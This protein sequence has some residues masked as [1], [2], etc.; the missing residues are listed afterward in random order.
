MVTIN[1]NP[2][3]SIV[4]PVYNGSNYVREAIDSALAQTYKNIEI[5]VVNDGSKDNTEEI[6][7]SYGDKV[8]YFSKEN[9]GTTTAL[10]VGI[11]NM[12]GSYFSWLSHD[13][14]YYPTKIA[15]Q[16]DELSKLEN[17]DTIIMSDLDGINEKYKK[18]YQTDY[19]KH[20]DKYPPRLKS[21][22]HPVIYNQT[23]GCTLLI[24][25][26]CFDTVGLFDESQL[27]AQ[28]FEFF[29]RAFLKFPHKLISEVLVTARDSSKRQ[30]IRSKSRGNEEYSALFI[31]VINN[32]TDEDIKLL[33]SDKLTFYHDMRDFFQCAE[34]SIALEYIEKKIVKNLQISSYDLIGNKFN[35]YDLHLD[36]R[37]NAIDSKQLVLFKESDDFNTYAYDFNTKDATKGLIQERIF[38]ESDIVHLHLIH[39]IIDLNYLPIMTKLKPTIL[40]LHDPFFLGG[41]CVHHFD[42]KKW[43]V[44]CK[45]CS[46]INE[47]FVLDKD[48]SA[49][50]F[51]L[52]KQAIQNSQITAV[53]ASNWMKNKVEQSPIWQGKKAYLLPFGVNQK[54]FDAVDIKLAKAK[55]NIQEKSIT[56]MFRADAGSYKGL[57]IIKHALA[58]LKN[59]KTITLITV[60]QKGLLKGF[61][62]KF[63]IIEYGWIKD[64]KLLARLYQACDIFLMPSRQET[65]GMMAI[66]AMSCG[67]MVLAL[68]SD[69]SALPE[70]VNS[71]G[72]G[73]AVSEKYFAEELQ[74]LIDNPKEIIE[75]GK[76][77][78]E[79]A[80]ENYSKDIYVK[81]MISIYGEVMSNHHLDKSSELILQQLKK[82][83][84][85]GL[86]C[87]DNTIES[88]F[89]REYLKWELYICSHL[90]VSTVFRN[91]NHIPKKIRTTFR[92]A[93]FNLFKIIYYKIYKKM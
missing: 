29:Y 1:F 13:D 92:K 90:P 35:G 88:G 33:A 69:G 87:N 18:I 5:I 4:I 62:D 10:N 7:K 86:I 60:G 81:K 57:D 6:V 58:R 55:F 26:V 47:P 66:E 91:K 2:L 44:H 22:I 38:F 41:H 24:P 64:D 48:I 93:M 34:Y 21:N 42:C 82:N 79:F 89:S 83:T 8:R 27:V 17:R 76:K 51:E 31:S 28:D 53:V 39:N 59:L 61:E 67:K 46:Y 32:L 75:R 78:L 50:N 74:K 16:V 73:L 45:D 71:P 19:A 52:K 63:N 25:K 12:K 20:I 49:L 70:V 84:T 77:S 3:I 15:R 43:Q 85:T 54:L 56:I 40:S 80:K 36:L 9:G 30:G 68:E 72:C 65:F 23:H 37:K 14:M 11:K